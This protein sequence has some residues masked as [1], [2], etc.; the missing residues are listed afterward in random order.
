MLAGEL[1]RAGDPELVAER[2][3]CE[4]LL[5]ALNSEPDEDARERILR[6]LLAALGSSSYIRSPFFCDYG[7]NITLGDGVFLN[8]NCVVLDVVAVT[9]GD[10][11]Q[12]ASAVQILAADHPVDVET[13]ASGLENGR[14]IAIEEDVWIGGGAILCPGV[15]VGRGSVIGAGSVV[16]RDIPA[17]VVAVGNPC[18]VLHELGT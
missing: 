7:Y 13:R 8:F 5:R 12:I 9:I 11:T 14:P 15:T 18:R 16:T 17:G 4:R 10:R 2:A 6:E 3:R 1:Y